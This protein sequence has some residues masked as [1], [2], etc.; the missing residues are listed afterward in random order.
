M[1]IKVFAFNLALLV[2]AC[3]SPAVQAQEVDGSDLRKYNAERQSNFNRLSTDD[4]LRVR[5]AQQ[6]AVQDPAV[7]AAL[8]KRNEAIQEFRA[9]LRTSMLK[10][11]PSLQSIIDQVLPLA[12]ESSSPAR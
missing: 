4:Q 7:Q 11:D 5:A 8:K 3:L 6:T 10:A 1:T 9:A 2:A 12:T